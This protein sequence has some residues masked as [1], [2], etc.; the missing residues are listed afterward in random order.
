M[1]RGGHGAV[2]ADDDERFDVL[3]S[4]DFPGILDDFGRHHGPVPRA[5]FGHEMSAIGRADNRAAQ[6]HDAI[7]A[8]AIQNRIIA[9]RKESFEA[10]AESD[11]F[12]A[13]FF[14]RQHD[15]AQHGVKTGAI[16]ATREN[17][18]TWLHLAGRPKALSADRP[19]A[20]P[21]PTGRTIASPWQRAVILPRNG[22]CSPIRPQ[23]SGADKPS[24]FDHS[25]QLQIR[26]SKKGSGTDRRARF[27]RFLRHRSH[28]DRGVRW[29]CGARSCNLA[30]PRSNEI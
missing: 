1:Q 20:R 29:W 7:G 10:I 9:R 16:A 24:S 17:A 25:G 26:D 19:C 2:A 28:S 5:D 22:S 4:Q 3:S 30:P 15:A 23:S 21:P 14:G 13:E 12:P 27:V 18:N 6:R 11:Y 8:V